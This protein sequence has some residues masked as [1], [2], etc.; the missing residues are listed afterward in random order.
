[1]FFSL[2]EIFACKWNLILS[3]SFNKIY[4]PKLLWHEPL[5]RVVCSLY[6]GNQNPPNNLHVEYYCYS[7]SWKNS[8]NRKGLQC[9]SHNWIMLLFHNRFITSLNEYK[10]FLKLNQ[11]Y[12]FD[13][14]CLSYATIIIYIIIHSTKAWSQPTT[15][16]RL[17]WIKVIIQI[18]WKQHFIE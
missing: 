5:I 15:T 10:Q 17:T 6:H 11:I 14:T 2:D 4:F 1:M 12:L 18:G 7:L 9:D 16:V 8:V 3:A 13:K